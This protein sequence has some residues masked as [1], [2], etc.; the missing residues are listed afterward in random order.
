MRISLI[1]ILALVFNG[2]VNQYKVRVDFSPV[3]REHFAELP[4]IEVDI[5]AVTDGEADEVKQMGVE[6]YFTPGSGIREKLQV[7]TC[8]FSREEQHSFVLPSRVPIWQTWLL[9]DP[10]NVLVIASLPPGPSTNPQSD[11]RLLTVTMKRSFIMARNIY[12]LVESDRIVQL[13][14]SAFRARR[15]GD[16]SPVSTEQW[17]EPRPS[18]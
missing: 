5:A 8:F 18:R 7:Q 13:T 6:E 1:L 2:C 9:K 11:P 4:T 12:I 3:L 17:I 10:T 14:S 15:S 16:D